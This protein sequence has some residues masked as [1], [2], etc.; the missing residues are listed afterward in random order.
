M[1]EQDSIGQI[2]KKVDYPYYI[3]KKTEAVRQKLIEDGVI[4]AFHPEKTARGRKR[5]SVPVRN[6]LK[7]IDVRG[8][9][10][11]DFGCGR[12]IDAEF[13]AENGANAYRYDPFYAPLCDAGA[14]QTRDE[15]SVRTISPSNPSERFDIAFCSYVLNVLTPRDRYLTAQLLKK[16]AGPE[17]G[18]IVVGVREDKGAVR[19][20]WR[21]YEDGYITGSGSFQCFFS[22]DDKIDRK[23]IHVFGSLEINRIGRSTYIVRNIV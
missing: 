13:L 22:N 8:K 15:H 2:D 3:I 11:L 23:L 21:E 19:E 10:V 20:N 6:A 5:P 17:S 4:C 16:L 14:G 7:K 18:I 9:T 1:T 12:S